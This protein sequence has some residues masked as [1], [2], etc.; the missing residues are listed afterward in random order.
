MVIVGNGLIVT[1]TVLVFEQPLA[2]VPVTVYT[3][4]EPG[5]AVVA[6]P[7]VAVNPAD[8]DHV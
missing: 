7:E 4:V 5:E 1:V 6:L 8:G 3:V 2:S